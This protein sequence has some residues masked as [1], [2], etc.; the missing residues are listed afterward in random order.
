[1]I[2][3]ERDMQLAKKTE[4]LNRESFIDGKYLQI[5]KEKA[6]KDAVNEESKSLEAKKK[7]IA[8][9]EE[10]LRQYNEQVSQRAKLRE[11]IK[12]TLTFKN[13]LP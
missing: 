7:R 4:R 5:Q 3:Q 13:R 11:V 1:M 6:E 2:L 12:L 9:A 8:I 10:Q